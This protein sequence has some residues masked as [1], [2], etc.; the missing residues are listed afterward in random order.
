MSAFLAVDAGNT[1]VKVCRH[2][3]DGW[4]E[5]ATYR[6]SPDTPPEAWQGRLA[7]LADG[8]TRGG[9]ATVVPALRAPILRALR[10][11][12]GAPPVDVSAA[13]EL[14][15]AMGYRTPATLGADR[16]AAAVAAWV[17]WGAEA[18]RPVVALDAGTA[19]TLD[20]VDLGPEGPVYRGGAILPGPRTL[21]RALAGGTAQLPEVEWERPEVPIGRSTAEAIQAGLATLALD[22]VAGLLA[23]TA[24]AMAAPPLVVATGGWGHW[25]A[26]RLGAVDAVAPRLVHEGVRLLGTA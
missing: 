5:V 2:D 25:F 19:L 4:G 14:P 12:T 10:D 13:L 26:R 3:G 20:C 18:G 7:R 6:T 21:A 16:L 8:A 15:F 24:A 9:L 17:G 22:G 23:R 11:A 1:S